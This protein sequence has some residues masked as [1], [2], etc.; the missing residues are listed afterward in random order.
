MLALFYT[1]PDISMIL[2]AIFLSLFL[3]KIIEKSIC[4]Y[5][6]GWVL[7]QWSVL[8]RRPVLPWLLPWLFW[9]LLFWWACSW[10]MYAYTSQLLSHNLR[11]LLLLWRRVPSL[12]CGT[13]VCLP[14]LHLPVYIFINCSMLKKIPKNDIE[15]YNCVQHDYMC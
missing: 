13:W 10:C 15:Q 11:L 4:Y 14:Y 8:S 7:S 9:C 1:E 12:L 2:K 3:R 5:S 6:P